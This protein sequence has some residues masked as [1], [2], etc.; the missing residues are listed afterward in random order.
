[1]KVSVWTL[2]P[3]RWIAKRAKEKGKVRVNNRCK[4]GNQCAYLLFWKLRAGKGR[5]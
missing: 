5:T 3:R 4:F 1:M 2:V